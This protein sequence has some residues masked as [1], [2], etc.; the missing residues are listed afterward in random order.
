MKTRTIMMIAGAAL[1]AFAYWSALPIMTADPLTW[2]RPAL[3]LVGGVFLAP[4]VFL[5]GAL[6]AIFG[7]DMETVTDPAF[8]LGPSV[9][10]W[11]AVA[12][13]VR[14][15]GWLQPVRVGGTV[16]CLQKID[17]V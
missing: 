15:R 13:I 12:F 2:I 4:G 3:A 9:L 8:Y 10:F 1:I 16:I 5:V 14:R 7:A 11:I 6:C 17:L